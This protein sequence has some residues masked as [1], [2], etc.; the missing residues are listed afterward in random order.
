MRAR[1]EARLS[2]AS[3]E[4]LSAEETELGLEISADLQVLETQPI[5]IL[6]EVETYHAARLVLQAQP[7]G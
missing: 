1:A 2:E 5:A 6:L 7:V 3:P 4:V